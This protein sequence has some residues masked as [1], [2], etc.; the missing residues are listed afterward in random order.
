MIVVRQL[1]THLFKQHFAL[2][3]LALAV[4]LIALASCN[5]TEITSSGQRAGGTYGGTFMNKAYIYRESPAIVHGPSYGPTVSMSGSLDKRLPEYITDKTLL[6]G[7]C[8]ISLFNG[9]ATLSDCIHSYASKTASQQLL[10]RKADGTWI[11]PTDSSEFYQVNGLYHVQ[12]G[13]D[14]FFDKLKFAYDS[15]HNNP[16]FMWKTKSTPHYLPQTNMYWF[17]AITPANDN[18]FRN[19]FLSSYALC[20]LELNASFSPAGPELCFGKWSNHPSFFFVQDPSIIYHELGHALI[21]VMMNFRNGVPGGVTPNLHSLRSNLGGYGYDEAGSLGEGIADYYSFVMNKRTH[22]GEWALAKSLNASRPM[23]E[24][25]SLHISGVNTTSEG[26]LSYPQYVL[27]DPNEPNV[28]FEAVH[29]SGQIVGHYLVSL[30]KTLQTEC[31]IPTEQKHDI[32][33]SYV[34]MLLAET[35]SELGDLKAVGLDTLW[36]TAYDPNTFSYRFNN[37]D[38]KASFVW[39]H[40]VNPPTYR[41]FFQ[42]MSKNIMKYM[43][44]G[45]CT[46]FTQDESEKLLDDYGLLLFKTYNDDGSSTKSANIQY[47]SSGNVNLNPTPVAPTKVHENNRRKSVLISKQ[48]LSLAVP[49]AETDTAT[50]YIIDDQTSMSGILQN[51]LFKGFP[52][53]PS[54]G[55]ASIEYNNSNIRISPGEIVAIIPNLFNSSNSPMAGVH[56]LANDWDHVSITDTTG[57]NGNFKPCVV[58]D[59]TTVAQGGEAGGTC[60]NTLT[61][62]RRHVKS[63]VLPGVW[64]F[65]TDEVAAPVCLVQLEDGEV[66]KW[67]SQNEFRKKQGLSLQDKDCLGYGGTAYTEDFTFNPHECLVRALPGANKAFYSKIDPQKSYSETMRN[68]NPDHTFGTGN[69]ILF[70]VNKWI[71]PG[72]KFRCRLRAKFSNCSDCFS[73]A[74]D[75]TE[76]EYIDAEY[77]GANPF[78][79]INFEFDVND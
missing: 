77:N 41:R 23:S 63:E 60:S 36:G 24:D 12:H 52:M 70:E 29:Y 37:L 13:V 79:I 8:S 33:T 49:N 50:Y 46:G 31:N 5:P 61:E 10:P 9:S 51:L 62:Y 4:S 30:T 71:P 45:L 19:S 55:V 26:R 56:L 1:M 67:V 42:V 6:K 76:D 65:R 18:Y 54:T 44:S 66:T 73:K 21:A 75:T 74:G 35:L 69:A 68:G 64:K 72:T 43:S 27:Y 11:F 14:T 47:N 40:V 16:M 17:Q 48:L 58:D 38:E 20:N 2:H 3:R 25:D 28:P 7:D 39:S 78:K 22:I 32:S 34:M 59:V 15:L 53:N 57:D